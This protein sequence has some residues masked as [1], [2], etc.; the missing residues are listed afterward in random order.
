MPV[1]TSGSTTLTFTVTYS[2]VVSGLDISSLSSSNLTV[3]GPNGYGAA[4][5]SF[6]SITEPMAP[7]RNGRRYR[8]AAPGGTWDSTDNGRLYS[9]H[10]GGP[11]QV[12]DVA[13]KFHPSGRPSD[14][15]PS[16]LPSVD[17]WGQEAT[18]AFRW[19]SPSP[20]PI[21]KPVVDKPCTQTDRGTG[22]ITRR[23]DQPPLLVSGKTTVTN[24][25]SPTGSLLDDVFPGTQGSSTA[26]YTAVNGALY[27]V[28]NSISSGGSK[29]LY[30]TDGTAAGTV[31]FFRAAFIDHDPRQPWQYPALLQR[32]AVDAHRWHR[33]RNAGGCEP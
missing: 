19:S 9:Y 2:D 16:Q 20:S 22:K 1:V 15:S 17:Y 10:A 30:K 3:T 4:P 6:P 12:R 8:V 28:A 26:Q 5:P 27:F 7:A 25:A 18:A 21:I 32:H 11:S 33:F 13:G 24:S 23:V 31:A 29:L 14:S